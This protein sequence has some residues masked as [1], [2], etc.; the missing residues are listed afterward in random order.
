MEDC[1]KIEEEYLK[2]GKEL[3][4]EKIHVKLLAMDNFNTAYLNILESFKKE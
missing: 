3:K 4:R 1:L 2:L